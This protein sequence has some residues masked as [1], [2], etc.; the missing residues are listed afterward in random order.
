MSLSR[1]ALETLVD[2]VEIKLSC[3]EVY[4]REDARE[5]QNLQLCRDELVA[6]TKGLS[7]SPSDV[8]ALEPKRRRG[9]PPLR[10][11]ARAQV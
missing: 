5:L 11:Q 8:V 2:L 3:V 10:P 9:R 1:R 7:K 4:D 6:M